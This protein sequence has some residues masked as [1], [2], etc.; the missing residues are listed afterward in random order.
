M[1]K[2]YLTL[3][4]FVCSMVSIGQTFARATYYE[5]GIIDT[6][7]QDVEW[8]EKV[9]MEPALVTLGSR[10]LKIHTEKFQQYFFKSSKYELA[11]V[12]GYYYLSYTAEGKE[13]VIYV[14]TENDGLTY[15]EI[16]NQ[17][18]VIRYHLTNLE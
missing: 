13:C 3:L 15:L 16:E 8:E 14:Y 17:N 10:N 5:L 2:F 9:K 1:R 6:I 4:F 12:K 7:T 18:Y 11:E